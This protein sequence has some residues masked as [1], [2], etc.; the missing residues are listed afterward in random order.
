MRGRGHACSRPAHAAL[1]PSDPASVKPRIRY[2]HTNYQLLT[3]VAE[4]VT[5]ERMA[6]LYDKHLF[7]PLEL[8]R[9]WLPGDSPKARVD[10]PATAW[11]GDQPLQRPSAM[12]SFKDLYATTDD[13]LS[14]GQ[15]WARGTLFDD[16]ATHELMR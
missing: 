10:D 3:V 15:A 6:M 1:P 4:H 8:A 9:T 12:A 11:I 2:S 16:P 13:V 5:G 14:F 7:G